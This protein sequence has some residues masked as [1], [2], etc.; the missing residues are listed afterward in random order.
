MPGT[1][2]VCQITVSELGDVFVLENELEHSFGLDMKVA[3]HSLCNGN[4]YLKHSSATHHILHC[5]TCH[6]RVPVPVEV[7]NFTQLANHFQQ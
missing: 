7:E 1:L 6:I 2:T 5:N 4:V 3:T